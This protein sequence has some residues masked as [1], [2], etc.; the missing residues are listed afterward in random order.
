MASIQANGS[1]GHHKFIL[2]VKQASQNVANN[3]S[4]ISFTFKIAPIETSWNWEQW[5][6]Y[7]KYTLTINGVVYS[8]NIDNYDGYSTITLKSGSQTVT[9]NADGTKSISYSFSVTDTSGVTYTSGN[10]SESG[11]MALTTIARASKID[12]FNGN[13]IEGTFNVGFTSSY[14]GFTHKLRLSIPNVTVLETFNNYTSGKDVKFSQTTLSY[15]YSYTSDKKS[16]NVGAVI[17]TWNGNT[18][19]GESAEIVNV[20]SVFDA[21]PSFLAS[22]L[23]YADINSSVVAIT[24]NNKHIV[25][26]K[27]NLRL[28]YTKAQSNKGANISKYSFTLNGV[29]KESTSAGGTIDFGTVNSASNV[30]LTATVTDTRGN[31]TTATIPITILPYEMPNAIVSLNRKNNYENETY[32][33]VDGSIASVNSKNKMTIQYRYKTSGGS[34]NSLATISDNTQVTLSLDNN[35]SFIFNVIVTD[36]FGSTY[37]KE[38]ILGKGV[39]PLFLD[40]KLNSVGINCLP[41]TSGALELM[42]R[43]F[44]NQKEIIIDKKGVLKGGQTFTHSFINHFGGFIVLRVWTNN[45][46]Y[47]RIYAVGGANK[48]AFTTKELL[49]H[50]LEGDA[51]ARATFNFEGDSSGSHF[52]F[53]VNNTGTVDLEYSIN[54]I[55]FL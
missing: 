3:T 25:Q 18:K 33:K 27:S 43:F 4:S 36:S 10:A 32:L 41:T 15:L 17:E 21:N 54:M 42:G 22:N 2:E 14:N 38:Y 30:N 47:F 55:N 39:F 19:V 48:W 46:E 26:N 20:F 52:H 51:N 40:T 50:T 9:H 34:Y 24:G 5:G 49:N 11:T 28:T 16:I 13:N 37:N 6:A 45:T 1:K 35:N 44:F 8:G 23:S 29:T 53:K 31:Q 12:N 7:I